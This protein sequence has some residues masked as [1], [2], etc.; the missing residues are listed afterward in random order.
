MF[1]Q[2]L[3]DNGMKLEIEPEG[4]VTDPFPGDK[5]RNRR[6]VYY[7][8]F[9]CVLKRGRVR[10]TF[11]FYTGMGWAKDP[12]VD[13]VMESV[14]LDC[15]SGELDFQDFCDEFGYDSDSRSAEKIHRACVKQRKGIE[16]VM[17]DALEKFMQL[18]YD[19][20]DQAD[21]GE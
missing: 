3:K 10:H 21:E 1:E 18:D 15:Q 20:I 7:H 16:R 14:R 4:M 12:T 11:D 5:G 9:S 19:L 2:F 8:S 17:G 13:D 6:P